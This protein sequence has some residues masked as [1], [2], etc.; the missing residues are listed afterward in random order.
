MKKT[1]IKKIQQME[2]KRFTHKGST[3]TFQNYQEDHDGVHHLV[4]AE[5]WFQFDDEQALK[6]F[7]IMCD[8][9][10]EETDTAELLPHR[11][12]AVVPADESG[13]SRPNSSSSNVMAYL[14]GLLIEDIDRV[15]EDKEYVEQA[16]T[17]S[18]NVKRLI[19]VAKLELEIQKRNN[20]AHD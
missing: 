16:K 17:V 8:I 5:Q 19:D 11:E 9:V 3:Y 14:K 2:G 4:T 15:R 12:E 18:N 6:D 10:E 13:L 20:N 1:R 7:L